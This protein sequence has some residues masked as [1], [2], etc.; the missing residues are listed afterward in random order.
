MHSNINDRLDKFLL[1]VFE[2][3]GIKGLVD[4]L[5]FLI[6]SFVLSTGGKVVGASDDFIELTG[7]TRDELYNMP[8][9]DLIHH[10]ERATLKIRL[11]N[12]DDERYK[13]RLLTRSKKIKT[14]IVSPRIL[15]FHG[16]TYRLAHFIDITAEIEA[17][18]KLKSIQNEYK[19]IFDLAAIGIARLNLD[20][21]WLECNPKLCDIVGYSSDELMQLTF[22]DI[23]HPDDLSEDLENVQQLLNGQC[24]E[25][26]M[27]K[28]YFHK[29]GHIIWINLTV[30]L[31]RDQ[32]NTPLYFV[33]FIQDITE[34]TEAHKLIEHNEHRFREVMESMPLAIYVSI[35]KNMKCELVN[36]AF[37]AIFGYTQED[38]PTILEWYKQAYPEQKYRESVRLEWENRMKIATASQTNMKPVDSIVTCKDGSKKH[39]RWGFISLVD[40]DYFF[41]FDITAIKKAEEELLRL[42]NEL[43]RLSFVDSLT[44]IS[45]RRVFDSTL[46]KE[47]NRAL[48]YNSS[49]A[50]IMLDIDYFKLYNDY[51]GHIQGDHAL[52]QV[53]CIL[54]ETVSRSVDMVARF[55]GE[56]FAILLPNTDLEEAQGIARKCLNAVISEQIENVSSPIT[57]ILTISLGVAAEKPDKHTDKLSLIDS[58]DKMLYLAKSRGRNRVEPT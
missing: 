22:Q 40:F 47:W 41:G 54:Q 13:L 9:F 48:R 18:L 23:T 45:N 49:I 39:I 46:D 1:G 57:N 50:L 19:F 5:S 44:N 37:T 42:N 26:S 15:V 52:K 11:D 33:S 10:D 7:Y 3:E 55:G 38:V 12:D 14:A 51:Y 20:G 53:A 17:K 8:V 21:T 6:G 35:G 4:T 25:Y 31:C 34:V 2:D 16:R 36:K 28:R 29:Q 43:T 32:N 27:V 58:A 30:S 56:E 24:Q